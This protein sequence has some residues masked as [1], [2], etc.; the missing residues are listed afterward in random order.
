MQ[1]RCRI[2]I[3]RFQGASRLS[4]APSSFS[5]P[6]TTLSCSVL[7]RSSCL[8]FYD[9]ARFCT[10]YSSFPLPFLFSPGTFPFHRLRS[11]SLSLSLYLTHHCLDSDYPAQHFS[12][13]THL[14]FFPAKIL[15][16][17]RAMDS[18][19]VAVLGDGGVGKTALAVQAS[20][21]PCVLTHPLIAPQFT[22]NCFVGKSMYP[23]SCLTYHLT[24]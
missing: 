20:H 1:G 6:P 5:P 14:L 7:G 9:F 21:F 4:S 23:I 13:L 18:W 22:L 16:C 17:R 10:T 24:P 19:R 12:N 3:R 8:H 15:F 11:A 2:E